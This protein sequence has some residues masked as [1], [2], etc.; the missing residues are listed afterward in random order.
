MA[1]I[2]E[3]IRKEIF[4]E[5]LKKRVTKLYTYGE[6]HPSEKSALTANLDGF[7]EAGPS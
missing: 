1:L 5:S 6:S 3:S 2:S 4:V 7:L